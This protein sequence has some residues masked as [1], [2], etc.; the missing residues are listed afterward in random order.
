LWSGSPAPVPV[1]NPLV[2]ESAEMRLSLLP[3]LMEN[4]RTNV[5]QQVES[6]FAYHLG[7]V[8]A[9]GA[10]E[11]TEERQ[12]LAGLLYGP[13]LRRGLR[14]QDAAASFLDC[15]GL[16]EGLLELL[17]LR[18]GIAWRE[19][20]I[21]AFH[22]GRTAAL[23]CAE[24]RIGYLGEIHPQVCDDLKLPRF[25]AFELDFEELLQ[26]A[27]RQITA[28]PLPRFP[29][30]E[31][32]LA[33]VVDR[34]FPSQKIISWVENLGESLIKHI[35]VFDQYLGSP[36]PEGKKSLAYKISYRADDRTLTDAE[37]HALHQTIVQRIGE[38]FGAELRS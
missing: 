14:H 18:D 30:V 10:G 7:K 35:E 21:P 25:V 11:E 20:P 29:A 4:L 31:R 33:V 2:K 1:E 15:K 38:V 36:I 19:E 17:R 34:A 13:R 26:Y 9:V 28:R 3:G 12:A 32:D 23:Y 37:V 16:V 5:A 6:F 22:P 8:F 24:R 27:P